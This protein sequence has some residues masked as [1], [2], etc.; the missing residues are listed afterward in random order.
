M[1]EY[2]QYIINV[3]RINVPFKNVIDYIFPIYSTLFL[4]LAVARLVSLQNPEMEAE[5]AASSS[6]KFRAT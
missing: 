1:F 3:K 5:S 2:M 6:W 4:T